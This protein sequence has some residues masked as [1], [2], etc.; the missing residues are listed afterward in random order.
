V[1]DIIIHEGGGSTLGVDLQMAPSQTRKPLADPE[2]A[3]DSVYNLLPHALHGK[4]V[5]QFF[6]WPVQPQNEF[7]NMNGSSLAHSWRFSLADISELIRA[8][9]D[10]RRLTPEI[11]AFIDAPA[12]VAIL[13][14]QT[15]TLQ[16]PPE[17]P[18]GSTTPYLAELENTY[19]AGRHLDA[20][21]SFV[22]ERQI[23]KGWLDRYKLPLVPAV[24]NIP[25]GVVEEIWGRYPADGAPYARNSRCDGPGLRSEFLAGSDAHPGRPAPA[26]LSRARSG[27]NSR[28]LS[29]CGAYPP[30]AEAPSSTL[31][32]PSRNAITPAYSTLSPRKPA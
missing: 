2:M 3:L 29:R 32:L 30:W 20:K 23:L 1:G 16:L 31:K 12:E 27:P 17:M 8:T 25:G 5:M 7:F 14:S 4:T 10:A 11:G 22:T 15:A 28:P 18:T 26:N 13:Y 21:V 24:R 19:E 9:L 6:H